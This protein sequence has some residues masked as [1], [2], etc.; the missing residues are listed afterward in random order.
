MATPY[1]GPL[2]DKD[3]DF[4]CI[5]DSFYLLMNLNQYKMKPVI[6]MTREAEGLLRIVLFSK[7]LELLGSNKTLRELRRKL[8]QDLRSNRRRGVVPVFISTLW[9]MFSLGISIQ[10]GELSSLTQDI[11]IVKWSCWL[12]WIAQA[13]GYLGDN[14]Q[15]HDLAIGLFMSW[16]PILILCSIVDRNPVASDDIQRKLNKMVDLVC[17]SLL[18]D[19]NREK[20]I[21]TFRHRPE[22]QKMAYWVNKISLQAENIKGDYFRGFAGQGRVRFHYGAAHAILIDIEKSY[23]AEHGRNWLSDEKD[24]R[25]NLVLGQVDQGFVWF[26][27]RQFWQIS[28]A[29]ACVAGTGIGAFLISY[30]TPTVGLSCRSGGYMIFGVVAFT[31]L[32]AEFCVWWYTSP[33]RK[34]KFQK[35][36]DR[37]MSD[38]DAR[39]NENIKLA[40]RDFKNYFHG[41]LT[42][43][44]DG[45]IWFCQAAT[46]FVRLAPGNTRMNKVENAIRGH[47]E[48]LRDLNARQWTE[49]CFFMPLEIFNT[50]WLIYLFMAQTVGAFQNCTCQTSPW[51]PGAGYLDFTAWQYS[52]SPAIEKYWIMGTVISCVVMGLGMLYIVIEASTSAFLS[53]T[54]ST[55]SKAY[56]MP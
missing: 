19:E 43:I 33:I 4:A 17:I 28:S 20:F 48:T 23:I 52:N 10:S 3:S 26:D 32:L 2:P 25:T 37:T 12:I 9:F 14:A 47:F 45:L 50:I 8:A 27:G 36:G 34:G 42:S 53:S 7:D 39:A 21:S 38:I 18:D 1:D 5:R 41:F 29:F 13:F 30:F 6:S 15:A 16:F 40:T 51:A 11:L 31:L 55:V 24:A 35:I 22:A 54:F 49:R 44:E 46:R 56:F